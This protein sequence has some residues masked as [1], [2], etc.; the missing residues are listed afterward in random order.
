MERTDI[1]L[2]NKVLDDLIIKYPKIRK[3]KIRSIISDYFNNVHR[4]LS[5]G[6]KLNDDTYVKRIKLPYLGSFSFNHNV[7]RRATEGKM[8]N[9]IDFNYYKSINTLIYLSGWSLLKWTKNKGYIFYN[10]ITGEEYWLNKEFVKGK[11]QATV[12]FYHYLTDDEKSNLILELSYSGKLLMC[13]NSG[14]IVKT[15]ES[16]EELEELHGNESTKILKSIIYNGSKKTSQVSMKVGSYIW[17]KEDDY[18]VLGIFRNSR[19]NIKHTYKI[20]IISKDT[21]EILHK[22]YGDVNE[23]VEFIKIIGD[24][25]KPNPS[26]IIK[27]LDTDNSMYGFKWKKS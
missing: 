23:C 3:T 10:D 15:L 2:I 14:D 21:G 20:D 24:Y 8:N 19:D 11:I 26:N 25:N 17:V 13:S 6:N 4:A 5:N 16:Y 9:M 7:L 22:D 27:K 18:N 1:Y 12:Y